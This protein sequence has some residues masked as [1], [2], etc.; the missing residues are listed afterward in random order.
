MV[1]ATMRQGD[2]FGG[3]RPMTGNKWSH[4]QWRAARL[5]ALAVVVACA[6]AGPPNAKQKEGDQ[7]L[8]VASDL[9][10]TNQP[11]LYDAVRQV[12][13]GWF[14]RR[15]PGRSGEDA[16]AVYIDNHLLGPPSTLRRLRVFGV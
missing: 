4:H 6:S 1:G 13:P 2:R 14:S 12:R 10:A 15:I 7:Y 8:I 5:A 16:I 11:T 9:Q 3:S